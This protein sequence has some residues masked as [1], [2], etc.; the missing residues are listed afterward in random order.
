MAPSYAAAAAAASAGSTSASR[1]AASSQPALRRM[2]P[3]GT[4]SCPQRA[5][6]SARGVHAA[7]ARGLRTRRAAAGGTAVGALPRR[8]AARTRRAGR[9]SASGATR[10][11]WPGRRAGRGSAPG[12]VAAGRLEQAG[13]RRARSRTARSS[14]SVE[15]G[16]RAVGEPRLEGSGDRSR[17]CAATREPAGEARGHGRPRS[18]SIRSPWPVRALVPLADRR[19]RRPR[20]SRPLA[21]RRRERVVDRDD[22]PVLVR[23]APRSGL[24]V[25]HVE[26]RVR[27]TSRASTSPA[28][29][30]AA[31][32]RLVSGRDQPQ[33]SPPRP[34]RCRSA[35]A[36]T[37]R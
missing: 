31:E 27:R 29:S 32:D 37:P 7:E 8:P 36:R 1:S 13:D 28:P 14:R 20:S 34:R 2:K 21:E 17:P 33:S 5:R 6:R 11:S 3:S 19:G 22:R 24:D 35:S 16:E 4:S 25:A 12:H 15:R 18:P 26:A 9:R 23:R 10:R 30:S